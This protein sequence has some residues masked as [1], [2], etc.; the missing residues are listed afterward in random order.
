MTPETLLAKTMWVLG[1]TGDP[2]AGGGAV[3]R[4]GQPRSTVLRECR[5]EATR[6]SAPSLYGPDRRDRRLAAVTGLAGVVRSAAIVG[7]L[8]D[9]AAKVTGLKWALM[10]GAPLYKPAA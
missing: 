9:G 1:R 8:S 2:R 3:L 10:R 4:A 5:G 6:R 7:V